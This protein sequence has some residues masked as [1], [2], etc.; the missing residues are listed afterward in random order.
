MKLTPKQRTDLKMKYGG[1]CAYCGCE[2]GAKWHADHLVAVVRDLKDGKPS[3]PENDCLEN[4]MPACSACN[5]N[6]RSMH[7]E[8]WRKMIA[9]YRD[10]QVIRDCSQLRHLVR[11]GLVEFKQVPIVFYFEK[12]E[13]L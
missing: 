11:F 7:L 1:R 3:K 13:A 8:D 6:K 10:V 4:L 5:Y 12:A 2:L 9:H